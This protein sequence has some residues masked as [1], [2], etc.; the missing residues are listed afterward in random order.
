[1]KFYI[2]GSITIAFFLGI[3]NVIYLNS[4]KTKSWPFMMYIFWFCLFLILAAYSTIY[5]GCKLMR[6]GISTQVRSLILK[7]HLLCI[8]LFLICNVYLFI[9]AI[10]Y[11][12][13]INYNPSTST[14]FTWQKVLKI[15][16][17]SQGYFMPLMRCTEEAF[18]DVIK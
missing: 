8:F 14:A 5:A 13:N 1:M 18:V 15:L 17:Y 12:T 7:R 6:P 2:A 4:D 11:A 10:V 16:Y 3:M 9:V